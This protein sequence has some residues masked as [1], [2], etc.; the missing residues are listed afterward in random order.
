MTGK[1]I[2]V[3]VESHDEIA[4]DV[5]QRFHATGE[6]RTIRR[7]RYE[8]DD[9]P[10]A[11]WRVAGRDGSDKPVDA[12]AVEV[13]DSGAGTSVLIWGGDHGLRLEDEASG[14]VIAEPYLL[15]PPSAL[16]D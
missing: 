11:T 6:T 12:R 3:F 1:F 8:P 15:L 9:G 14:R 13:D 16:L 2:E 5:C 4:Q 7:V 10:L